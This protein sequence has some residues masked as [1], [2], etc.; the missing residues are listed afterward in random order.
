MDLA[1][2]A[3]VV[4]YLGGLNTTNANAAIASLIAAESRAI[5]RYTA[6]K[7]PHVV[8]TGKRLNGTGTR[9][10]VLPDT[11]ILSVSSLAIDGTSVSATESTLTAGFMHDDTCLYLSGMSFPQG[12]QNVQ[13]SWIAGYT[14]ELV[15]L[16]PVPT[17]NAATSTITPD[18]DGWAGVAIS[19][20]LDGVAATQVPV[21]NVPAAGQFSLVDGAFTFNGSDAGKTADMIFYRIPGPVMQACIEMVALDMNQRTNA[22]IKSKTLAGES[23]GYET[24]GMTTSVKQM[25]A[26]FRRRTPA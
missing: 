15:D 25:L 9:M 8:L 21:A 1:T 3:Q 6:R 11:P 18:D 17:G 14:G 19:V 16:V 22:G 13:A 7:F 24:S 20:T 4:R 5:E 12:L 10:L 2:V 26:P 23:I